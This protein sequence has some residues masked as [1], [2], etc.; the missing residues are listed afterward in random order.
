MDH[1]ARTPVSGITCLFRP[2]ELPIARSTGVDTLYYWISQ[3]DQ[4]YARFCLSPLVALEH[5]RTRWLLL[6][7]QPSSQLAI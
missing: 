3:L 4:V 6:C 5:Q 7:S 1:V 2:G